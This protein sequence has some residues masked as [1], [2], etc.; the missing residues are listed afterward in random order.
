MPERRR[1]RG[2]PVHVFRVEEAR[3]FEAFLREHPR[4]LV[5]F[6]GTECPFAK[7]FRPV[8]EAASAAAPLVVRE[9]DL[10]QDAEWDEHGIE[11]TPTVVLFEGGRE[12]TRL[13]AKRGVGLAPDTFRA[14]LAGVA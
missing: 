1:A 4:A 6:H 3:A 12:K 9:L 7:R 2:V 5:H 14:W 8:F 10:T 13:E 11:V